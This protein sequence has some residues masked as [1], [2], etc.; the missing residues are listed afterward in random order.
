MSQ[1]CEEEDCTGGCWSPFCR[2]PTLGAPLTVA[3]KGPRGGGGSGRG[4]WKHNIKRI[5]VAW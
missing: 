1:G 5:I 4:L 2:P 3:R